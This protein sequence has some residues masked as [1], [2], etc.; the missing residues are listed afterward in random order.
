MNSS[1]YSIL[2]MFER[3]PGELVES[4]LPASLSATPS[5]PFDSAI[6]AARN[7]ATPRASSAQK[8]Q[9]SSASHRRRHLS[10]APPH[11]YQHAHFEFRLAI[12]VA[13]SCGSSFTPILLQFRAAK[14]R[15]SA[16][17]AQA[18]VPPTRLLPTKKSKEIYD[19]P[20]P[21]LELLSRT[22][23]LY[24]S[25]IPGH[26]ERHLARRPMSHAKR[27]QKIERSAEK[28][29]IEIASTF[30]PVAAS[31]HGAHHHRHRAAPPW[32]TARGR[33]PQRRPRRQSLKWFPQVKAIDAQFFDRF[34]I[35]PLE[36][37]PEWK[38]LRHSRPREASPANSMP[39][40]RQKFPASSTIPQR[41]SRHG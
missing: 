39:S 28:T 5:L 1:C 40:S 7:P 3:A 38:T 8:N 41:L 12:S 14:Q 36:E 20:S 17:T 34:W 21:R 13:S 11:V 4:A 35:E 25:Q 2:G 31:H 9:T 22:P 6:A 23:L 10:I 32:R 33:T 24:S 15:Y 26:P 37:L 18:Y 16:S 29:P 19:L 27:L 30:L